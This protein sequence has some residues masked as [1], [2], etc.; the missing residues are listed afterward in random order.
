MNG[1][2]AIA[3]AH[4]PAPVPDWIERLAI[5]CASSSQAAVA[6]R[7][8]LSAGIISQALRQ[9]YPGD[10]VA[11][12]NAVRGAFMNA[13]IACPALGQIPTDQCQEWQRKSRKFS[14]ANNHRVRMFR[15]CGQCVYNRKDT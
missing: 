15:A 1:P 10:M 8:G 13:S 12:E 9:K 6:R 2:Q 14:N 4:W 5:A 7:L 3:A 11:V